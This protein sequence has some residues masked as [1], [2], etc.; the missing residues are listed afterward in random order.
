MRSLR[1]Q[2]EGPLP[3]AASVSSASN[4]VFSRFSSSGG[5]GVI[6]RK[7]Q[8]YAKKVAGFLGFGKQLYEHRAKC[9]P[10][11][12]IITPKSEFEVHIIV[13]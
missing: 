6:V 11:N 13:W 2:H 9:R 7:Q 1:A 3:Q 5:E 4:S 8:I 12:R 10:P